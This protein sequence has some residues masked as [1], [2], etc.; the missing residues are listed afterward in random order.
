[1]NYRSVVGFG[2]GRAVTDPQAQRRVFE[3]MVR[4]Y[5]VGRTEGVDYSAPAAEHLEGTTLVE[6]VME[7]WSAKAREGGPMG[8]LDALEGAPG[9]CG[10]VPL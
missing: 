10:V 9:T 2:R 7:E 5:F 1:M 6:L 4:R 3:A 8:P